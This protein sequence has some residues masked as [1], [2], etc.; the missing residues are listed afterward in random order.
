MQKIAIGSRFPLPKLFVQVYDRSLQQF[1]RG[2]Y[3]A[4]TKTLLVL[5]LTILLLTAALLNVH[6]NSKAQT[7]T[8]SGKDLTLQQVF[9]AIEKQTDYVAFYNVSILAHT[10]PVTL[11]VYSMPLKELLNTVF[12]NQPLDYTIEGKTIILSPKIIS[13]PLVPFSEMLS[14]EKP[15]LLITGILRTAEGELLA[16]ASVRLK[17]KSSGTISDS[18]GSFQLKTDEEDPV[19]AISMIGYELMEVNIKKTETGYTVAKYSGGM[20]G[21]ADVSTGIISFVFVMKKAVSLLDE[22]QV[23]AYG[24]TTRRLSTGSIGVIKGEDIANQPVM[25]VLE[26]IKGRVPGVIV[27][28]YSGNPAA[29]VKVIIRGRNNINENA[30]TDPLYVIDG[31]PRNNLNV[32][33]ITKNSPVSTGAVQGGYSLLGGENPL[34][35]I[36]PNDIESISI[37]KDADATAIY[38]SRGANGV[39]L[40]TTKKGKVGPTELS[41]GIR[42]GL[43]TLQRFP[44]MLNTA[45]YLAIRREAYRNDGAL[46][47]PSEAPDLLVW[48]ANK[49]TD[50]QRVL[51]GTG[52]TTSIN[53]SVGGGTN[54][55]NYR[56]SAGFNTMKTPMNIG[57]KNE[58]ISITGSFSSASKDQKFKFS[59]NNSLGFSEVIVYNIASINAL[60]PNSPDIYNQ[61]GELNFDG[62]RVLGSNRNPFENLKRPNSS[63][64]VFLESNASVSYELMKG[65]NV[66]ASGGYG[67]SINDNKYL[68]P[69]ASQ[70]PMAGGISSA[71]Y[72]KSNSRNKFVE[73]KLNYSTFIGKGDLS[74]MLAVN[75]Q[76]MTS[77][78]ETITAAMFP[79]D[80]MM[81][82]HNNASFVNTIENSEQYKNVSALG[83]INYT[84]DNKYVINLTGRRDGSSKFG[85]GKQFGNFGAIGLSWI[86]SDEKWLRKLLPSWFNMLKFRASYG[87]TGSDGIPNYEFLSRWSRN[88]T[89]T[90]SAPLLTYNGI[91]AFHVINP[92]NQQYQWASSRSRDIGMTMQLLGNNLTIDFTWLRNRTSNQLTNAPLPKMTGFATALTNWPAN[93]QNSGFELGINANALQTK[94][95]SISLGF[96]VGMVRNI[97]LDFPNIEN[98]PYAGILNPGE[99]ITTKY[100]LKY[101]G[102]NPATGNYSFE[103][104]NKDGRITVGGSRIPTNPLD[105]RYISIDLNEKYSGGFN[106]GVKFKFLQLS[107]SFSFVNRLR[108][109]PY[110]SSVVGRMTNISLPDDI[111]NNHWTQPG[112][113]VKY[114]RYTISGALGPITDSDANYVNGSYVRME[115]LFLS[116]QLPQKWVSRIKMKAAAISFATQNLFTISAFKG[117]GPDILSGFAA[118]PIPRVITTQLSLSF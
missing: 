118:T 21:S 105:D 11:T 116:C 61:K 58:M 20:V 112:D 53:A 30:L 82:S 39:I 12:R 83:G 40:I 74:L 72:G 33:V 76:H 6:A 100:L 46:P 64:S 47:T 60:A 63:N 108:D 45:E 3:G 109:D 44:K 97:L 88:V 36:N 66:S 111:K 114:P 31:V 7:V 42:N 2:G 23:I 110:L 55:S 35:G 93:V 95:W 57:G 90:T 81:K 52:S 38:G 17:G 19:L 85:P 59:I 101:T 73:S 25:G 9:A 10:K 102:V 28:P 79:N 24:K 78:G 104:Y 103:D 96:N 117:L 92:L 106:M 80:D 62:Y 107:T 14:T 94:N 54:Q 22:A 16:G 65:L 69:L 99:S 34:V 67:F 13:P 41:I 8:L 4:I 98:S 29:P 86:A 32:S 87:E 71:V 26:A 113:Q 56:L 77:M 51:A 15:P 37:L 68:I 18:K 91:N 115:N 27:T 50:W 89:K 70:D 48:D 84:W 5:K 49:Y 43:T 75:M 1:R